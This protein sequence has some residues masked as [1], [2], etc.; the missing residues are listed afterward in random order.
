MNPPPKHSAATNI[1]LRG[2]TRSTQRPNRAAARPRTAMAMENVQPTS[3]SFQSPGADWVIPD[4]LGERQV[5]GR[6]GVRLTDRQVHGEGR[7]GHH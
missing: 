3:V 2:P 1:D 7:R 5:E 6:E 4:Q